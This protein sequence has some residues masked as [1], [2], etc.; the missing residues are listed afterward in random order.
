M[1][2]LNR[3]YLRAYSAGEIQLLVV[4]QQLCDRDEFIME[5]CDRL[6]QAQQHYKAAYDRKH[7]D[8]EFQEGRWVWLRLLHRLTTSMDIKERGKLGPRFY[9]PFKILERV[10]TV[11]YRLQLPAGARIHDVYLVR[12]LKRFTGEPPSAPGTLPPIRHGRACL[13]PESVT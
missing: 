10:G 11:A 13:R 8:M 6:E 5:V 1:Y 4:Q 12:L 7:Q 2:G 9:R 3:S